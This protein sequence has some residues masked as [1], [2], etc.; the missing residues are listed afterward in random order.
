MCAKTSLGGVVFFL[1][2][3]LFS[4]PS[5]SLAQADKTYGLAVM[6]LKGIGIAETEA[7]A[8]TEALH[9]GISEIILTQGA[10]LTE[11]YS[12]L[13]RS[14]M[15]KILDQYKD[16]DLGCVDEKCAVEFGKILSVERIIIGSV[17]LVGETFNITGRIVDVESSKVIR[18][19]SRRHEGKIDGVLDIMP[20][21]GQELLTGVRPPDPVRPA[22]RIVPPVAGTTG[23]SYLSIE[24]TPAGADARINGQRIGQTPVQFYALAPGRYTVT[25]AA[26]E[27]EEFT[28]EVIIEPGKRHRL[29]YSLAAFGKITI[30]GEPKGAVVSVNGK[31]IGKTPFENVGLPAGKYSVRISR[32][33]YTG[34]NENITLASGAVREIVYH[35]YAVLKI[36]ISSMP[37][38]AEVRIDGKKAGE[39]PLADFTVTEGEHNIAIARMGYETVRQHVA[40]SPS[41]PVSISPVLVPKTKGKALLRSVFLPGTGQ[42]YAEYKAKGELISVFQLAALAGV[43]GATLMANDARSNYDHAYNAY[44]RASAPGDISAARD[45]MN[46]EYDTVSSAETLQLALIGAAA[47]V[48]AYNLI[49]AAFF[50]TPKIEVK[51]PSAYLRF[52]PYANNGVSGISASLR[53]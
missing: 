17:G 42:W 39:T 23:S 32:D 25:V 27:H 31:E 46:G 33:G 24:G 37:E 29:S 21:I 7:E 36:T 5:E 50:T 47:A 15:D 44:K 18:S 13:E 35:L 30:K 52:E 11:K 8:L 20:L 28:R 14:Q 40:V 3:V 45:D 48:Y 1:A 53:F 19:V 34:H 38:G 2:L 9:T 6:R 10:K 26:S 51:P 43:V 41:A 16:Q 22:Q 4:F 49:D 12:L